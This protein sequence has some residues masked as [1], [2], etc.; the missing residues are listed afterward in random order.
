[1]QQPAMRLRK[2]RDIKENA[3]SLFFLAKSRHYKSQF[4]L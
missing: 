2:M 4:M 1:M 3:N